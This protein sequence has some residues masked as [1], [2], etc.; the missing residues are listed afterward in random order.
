MDDHK[1]P[2]K[3]KNCVN[4]CDREFIRCVESWRQDCRDSFD[5]CASA[6][7]V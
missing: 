7:R 2:K 1:D 4:D 5:R 3:D 6:C